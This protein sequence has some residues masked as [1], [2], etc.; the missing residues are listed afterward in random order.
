MFD[1]E[2]V[3]RATEMFI[4][5]I[6]IAGLKTRE[7]VPSWDISFDDLKKYEMVILKLIK[8]IDPALK[9]ELVGAYIEDNRYLDFVVEALESLYEK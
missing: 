2:K 4:F 8:S 9:D 6:Y 3:N 7:V 5:D 1:I